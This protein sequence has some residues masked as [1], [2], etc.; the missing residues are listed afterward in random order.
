MHRSMSKTPDVGAV[1]IPSY[2][3][4][5]TNLDISSFNGFSSPVSDEDDYSYNDFGHNCST[6]HHDDHRLFGLPAARHAKERFI[7]SPVRLYMS[8]RQYCG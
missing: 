8:Y 2:A 5:P 1:Q 3:P 7:T 4:N 6:N